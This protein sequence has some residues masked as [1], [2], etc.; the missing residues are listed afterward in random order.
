M[1]MVNHNLNEQIWPLKTKREESPRGLF[2]SITGAIGHLGDTIG[3]GI[4]TVTNGIN[5]GISSA[6][7]SLDSATIDF[8]M[9]TTQAIS[10]AT[11]LANTQVLVPDFLD[12]TTTNG[13]GS[14]LADANGCASFSGGKAPSFVLL[15]FV[16]LGEGVKA[17]NL[18][19]GFA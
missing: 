11:D 10:S 3:T 5:S 9:K 1:F 19:N 14:I 18:L 12:A 15:D 17:V 8:I 4:G 6:L 13:V 2:D 16:D 7:A